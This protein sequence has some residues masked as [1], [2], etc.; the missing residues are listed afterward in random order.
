MGT[1]VPELRSQQLVVQYATL[2]DVV[3]S[4]D[5][6]LSLLLLFTEPGQR[7]GVTEMSRRLQIHKSTAS[8]LAAT[9]V[10]RGFLDQDPETDR[11]TLGVTLARL[12]LLVASNRNLI[13]ASAPALNKL[14]L[15]TGETA[16][17]SVLDDGRALQIAQSEGSYKIAARSWIGVRDPLHA[18]AIGKVLVA[19][20]DP[21]PPVPVDMPA[22][23]E[24]TITD[25]DEFRAEIERTRRRGY[26]TSVGELEPGLNVVAVPIL[27]SWCGCRGAIDVSGPANRMPTRRFKEIA[28]RCRA[29]ANDI[30]S[31]L[32]GGSPPM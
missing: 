29:A 19:F 2:L 16:N 32:E 13:T 25:P 6:A 21:R 15:D 11:F 28:V 27:D 30:A 4:V 5:R 23:T 24:R 14:A 9:L 17:V 7:F 18:T 22:Y 3:Q 8:R 12:G 1:S 20:S 31:R 26:G 10:Q